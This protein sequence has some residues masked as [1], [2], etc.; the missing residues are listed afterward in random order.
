MRSSSCRLTTNGL[1]VRRRLFP[2]SGSQLGPCGLDILRGLIA[3]QQ[4]AEA[5]PLIISS[6]KFL[7]R[8]GA[9][10]VDTRRRDAEI[11]DKI[12]VQIEHLRPEI[13]NLFVTLPLFAGHISSRNQALFSRIF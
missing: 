9:A 12:Q 1:G 6:C 10:Q 3:Q 13:W 5:I 8:E 2:Q 7:L 11:A 4:T